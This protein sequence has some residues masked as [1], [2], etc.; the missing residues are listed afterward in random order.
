MNATATGT[1]VTR[2][3]YDG[4]VYFPI[5]RGG[6]VLGP[7]EL[8]ELVATPV[9]EVARHFLAVAADEGPS[10]E[11]L[12]PL[13]LGHYTPPRA[14][15]LTLGDTVFTIGC[16]EALAIIP[17]GQIDGTTG[18][19]LIG[20]GRLYANALAAIVWP[21]IRSGLLSGL[22]AECLVNHVDDR[23]IVRELSRVTLGGLENN[24]LAGARIVKAWEGDNT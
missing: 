11:G 19:A 7:E 5:V 12:L 15:P 9:P 14:I 20:T 6:A 22:C 4:Q 1:R 13:D 10:L 8:A 17:D 21:V 3:V 23:M 2:L 24:G 18:R 16:I